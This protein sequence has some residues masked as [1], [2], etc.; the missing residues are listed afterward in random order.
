LPKRGIK[1]LLES[2]Y[3]QRKS[4]CSV[5]NMQLGSELR[6]GTYNATNLFRDEHFKAK[7]AHLATELS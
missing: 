7:R 4:R 5:K 6:K 2:R 1:T 3:S